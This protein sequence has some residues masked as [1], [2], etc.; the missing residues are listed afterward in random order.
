MIEKKPLPISS[1]TV[2]HNSEAIVQLFCKGMEDIDIAQKIIVDAGS[3]DHTVDHL[4]SDDFEVIKTNNCGFGRANNLGA[5]IAKSEYLLF[6]NPDVYIEHDELLA[7]F[8]FAITLPN[9]F[10]VSCKMATDLKKLELTRESRFIGDF[11]PASKVSGALL[12]MKTSTFNRLDGFDENLFLY[13][14]EIDLCRRAKGMGMTIGTYGGATVR[15][16]RA[17]STPVNKKYDLIRGW[18]DGWSKLYY[19]KKHAK[20]NLIAILLVIRTL[21]QTVSKIF[22]NM[23][24]GK[25]KKAKREYLKM[26]G[27]LAFCVGTNAFNKDGSGR[28]T[29]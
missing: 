26:R 14:D 8:N 19:L 21:I 7:L 2:T 5:K 13:F 24:L 10:I 16:L 9:D 23:I 11:N 18:H 20:T 28:F 4:T 27:M 3:N 6:I 12:L 25:T 1:I 17:G 22:I 29:D 15:H